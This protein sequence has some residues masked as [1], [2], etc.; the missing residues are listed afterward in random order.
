MEREWLNWKPNAECFVSPQDDVV[1]VRVRFMDEEN[2]PFPKYGCIV[3]IPVECF[4]RTPQGA[5]Y[6]NGQF[7]VEEEA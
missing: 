1:K 4:L 7:E 6:P 2:E 5:R 3:S